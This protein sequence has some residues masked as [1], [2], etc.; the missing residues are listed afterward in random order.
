MPIAARVLK[1]LHPLAGKVASINGATQ[2]RAGA[3]RPEIIV[4]ESAPVPNLEEQLPESGGGL[5]VGSNV[6]L[7]RMP[8]FGLLGTVAALPPQAQMLDTGAMARV[9]LATL[10]DGRVVTVPRANVE[11]VDYIES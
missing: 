1:L 2:V 5:H 3:V 8:Y 11:L 9:L 6:R 10:A 4:P 7:I